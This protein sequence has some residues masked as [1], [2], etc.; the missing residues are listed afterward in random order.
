MRTPA[1]ASTEL[2]QQVPGRLGRGRDRARVSARAG[3]DARGKARVGDQRHDGRAAHRL[4]DRTDEAGAVDDRVAAVDAVVEALVDRHLPVPAHVHGRVHRTVPAEAPRGG[5]RVRRP[6][7][8]RHRRRGLAGH[9]PLVCRDAL[10]V[11]GRRDEHADRERGHGD[12]RRRSGPAT[13]ARAGV[14]PPGPCAGGSSRTRT[15]TSGPA[16]RRATESHQRPAM[17]GARRA[18]GSLEG[19][20]ELSTEIVEDVR[21]DWAPR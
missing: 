20:I 4:C 21:H 16:A 2:E 18:F 15:A 5:T 17:A 7:S 6:R 19:R 10:P 9:C 13:A 8:R 3:I 1:S 11:Q 12:G 14:P